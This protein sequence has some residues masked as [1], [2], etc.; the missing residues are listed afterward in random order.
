MYLPL[1][2]G[3]NP[4]VISTAGWIVGLGGLAATAA[5]VA[6]LYR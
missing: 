1:Q 5:W 4:A 6:A 2:E 3:A